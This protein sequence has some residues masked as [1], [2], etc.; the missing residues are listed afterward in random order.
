MHLKKRAKAIYQSCL[1][2]ALAQG[3]IEIQVEKPLTC[4]MELKLLHVGLSID[5]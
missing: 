3:I 5:P 4:R 2:A 1:V